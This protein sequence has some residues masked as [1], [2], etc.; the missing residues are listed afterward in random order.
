MSSSL[1]AITDFVPIPPQWCISYYTGSISICRAALILF[2]WYKWQF[3]AVTCYFYC[4]AKWLTQLWK[5]SAAI[6]SQAHSSLH[7]PFT[8]LRP[9]KHSSE[10]TQCKQMYPNP[11]SYDFDLWAEN[12]LMPC[13]Y[14]TEFAPCQYSWCLKAFPVGVDWFPEGGRLLLSCPLLNPTVERRVESKQWSVTDNRGLQS[15]YFPIS[16][17]SVRECHDVPWSNWSPR[18][19][20]TPQ[21]LCWFKKLLSA[22]LAHKI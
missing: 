17:E 9:A 15:Q 10:V 3:C 6:F 11:Y 22:A 20:F 2:V 5:A 4:F 19:P 1:F 12:V 16:N 18:W 7:L 21:I 14:S 13:T 8:V